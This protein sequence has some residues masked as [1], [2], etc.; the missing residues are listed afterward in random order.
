MFEP[1]SHLRTLRPEEGQCSPFGKEWGVRHTIAPRTHTPYRLILEWHKREVE[2][3]LVL[4]L[5]PPGL[6]QE[7]E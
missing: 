1:I 6:I 4:M 5:V 2:A 7:L 3:G